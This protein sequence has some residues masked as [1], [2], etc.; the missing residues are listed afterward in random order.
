MRAPNNSDCA[1]REAANDVRST[2]V[3]SI[4]MASTYSMMLVP[5]YKIAKAALNM[6]TVLYAQTYADEGFTFLAVSPGVSTVFRIVLVALTNFGIQWLRTE[7]GGSSADL[8]AE[9][10]AKAVIEAINTH[11]K[12]SNGQFVNIRVAGWEH[13][14][15]LNQ[16]DGGNPPW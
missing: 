16:Y 14:E 7:L 8:D 12:E 6:L 4:S 15:G 11:G 10:G 5:S 3:G 9:T 13:N 1:H 2:T